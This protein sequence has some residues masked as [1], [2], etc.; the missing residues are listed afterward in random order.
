MIKGIIFDLDGVILSTDHFHYLAWKKM[1]DEEGI[2]FDEIINNRLRGVSRMASLEIILERSK[3]V[4][5]PMEKDEMANRKN[6]YYRDLLK[7]MTPNDVS[8]E[9]REVLKELHR[10][11]YLLAVGSS[12][13]N[14]PFIIQQV[15]LSSYFDQVVDGSM[16]SK[17]KPDP[18]VFLKAASLLG[19]SPS[20]CFVV[21]D[22]PAGVLAAKRGGFASIGIGLAAKDTNTDYPIEALSD[23]VLLV[24]RV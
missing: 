22:A 13:K 4:Y 23:I 21:E 10:L 19:L 17:S 20:S 24:N 2:Y 15:Q 12:S 9:N 18:E 7:T 6:G 3:K 1:A 5:S 8:D 16:I 14:A 11:G